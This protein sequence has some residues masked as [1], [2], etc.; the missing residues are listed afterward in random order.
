[1]V[2]QDLFI[3]LL[4]KHEVSES[5]KFKMD[6]NNYIMFSQLTNLNEN[7]FESDNFVDDFD[8]SKD[9]EKYLKFAEE[10]QNIQRSSTFNQPRPIPC[11]STTAKTDCVEDDYDVDSFFI[12]ENIEETKVQ[13]ILQ[14]SSSEINKFIDDNKAKATKRKTNTDLRQWYRFCKASERDAKWKTFHQTSLMLFFVIT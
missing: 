3:V 4:G 12:H 2:T 13:I 5:E 9:L 7:I 10:Q 14:D 8:W 11:P 6:E 1:M